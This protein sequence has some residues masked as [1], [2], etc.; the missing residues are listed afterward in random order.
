MR[1]TRHPTVLVATDNEDTR[2]MLRFWLEA[3]GYGVVEA[4]DGEEAVGLTCGG[5]LDL[6]LISERMSRLGG[7]E[8]ARRIREQVEQSICPIVCMSTYPTQEARAAALGGGC[9]SFLAEPLDLGDLFS[10][11]GSLLPESA[12]RRPRENR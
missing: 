9:D 4:A 12:S 1:E 10:L 2:S 3:E 11:L 6:I 5:R 8:V 7:L